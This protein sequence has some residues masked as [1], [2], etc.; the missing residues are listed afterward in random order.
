LLASLGTYGVLAYMVAGRTQEIG[1]RRALGAPPRHVLWLI[2]GQGMLVAV[3]GVMGGIAISVLT[4]RSVSAK[5]LGVS[6]SD[7][8]ILAGVG[9]LLLAVSISACYIPARRAM[10]LD[11]LEAV[12]HE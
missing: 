7:P 12:R 6:A 5:L 2:L 1:L 11:P 3:C 9:G 8:V 10:R 4:G